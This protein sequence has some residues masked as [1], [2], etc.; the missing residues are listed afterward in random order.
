MFSRTDRGLLS[1]WWWTV[2]RVL[3]GTL[4]ALLLGGLVLSLAGSP[5]VAQRLGV[6]SFHFVKRHALFLLPALAVLI[7]VSLMSER[8]IRRSALMVFALGIG[9]M[10]LTLLIG[11]EVKGARRWL[12]LGGF[13]IQAS[14]F[15]K[16]AFVVLVAWLFSERIRRPD[17]PG[18]LLAV[19]LLGLFIGLLVPQPDF[20]QTLLVL[21]VWGALFFAAGMSWFWIAL[22]GGTGVVGL[23]GAYAMVP[24]VR[25]RIDRFLDPSAGD[26]YQVDVATDAFVRGG[27]IGRGP[28]EGTVKLS[29]P[30]SHTDFIFAVA[31][32]EFGAVVCML[33]V[34]V[35]GFIVLRGLTHA[36]RRHDP[37]ARLAVTGLIVLVGLQAAIN[38]SVNLSLLPAK[39]MTLPFLSYGGS[40]LLSLAYAMGIVLALTRRRP[41]ASPVVVGPLTPRA[42]ATSGP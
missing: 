2:D 36:L 3:L 24:H 19:L 10:V 29:L 30:D 38:M 20:G 40:S 18:N 31:G 6:D 7:G 41:Q 9:L 5:P 13:A 11:T 26:T 27:W 22:L 4:I 1:E 25:L 37:F 32:E 16:P 23:V 15:V 42:A 8:Q 34:A 39:G 17:M 12:T 33:L 35:F 21:L 14:E 28:G